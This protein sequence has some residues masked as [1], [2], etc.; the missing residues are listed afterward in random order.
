MTLPVPVLAVD[1]DVI[2]IIILVL[3]ILGYFVKAIKGNGENVP[4]PPVRD[5]DQDRR[6]TEIETFLEEISGGNRNRPPAQRTPP[7]PVAPER[8]R[9]PASK[10]GKKAAKPPM[11][12]AKPQKA[13]K[14]LTT[15]ADKH[16]EAA[17]LGQSLR[18]H[19]AGYM[20]PDRIAAEVQQDLASR[21]PTGPMTG[22][23]A[24]PPPSVHPVIQFLREPQGVR[25][26]IVL[27]EILQRPKA[28]RRP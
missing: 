23:S 12:A 17:P 25:Q 21:L 7:A 16:L 4:R 14:P 11:A 22:L 18:A 2:G 13:T 9:P 26:A 28:L 19:V 15:L 6:R 8:P 20:Q 3:S 5:P 1:F 27:H 24:P 10:P